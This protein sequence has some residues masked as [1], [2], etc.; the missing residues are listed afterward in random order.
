MFK[1]V[2]LHLLKIGIAA[3]LIYWLM[4]SGKL[5]FKLLASLKNYPGSVLMAVLLSITNFIL[6]SFQWEIILKARSQ[7]QLPIS[8]LFRVT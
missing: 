8:G 3:G 2:L 7:V 4:T 5:D 1:N 6:V